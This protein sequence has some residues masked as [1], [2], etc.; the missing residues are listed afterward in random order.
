MHRQGPLPQLVEGHFRFG[1]WVGLV[2]RV[3][4]CLG[5]G[6]CVFC[7]VSPGVLFWALVLGWFALGF[8]V[9]VLLFHAGLLLTTCGPRT[10]G[11]LKTS[12]AD[13]QV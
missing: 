11:L 12:V 13:V 5:P 1:L 10:A 4:F 6:V 8:C 9:G 2:S 7:V 3:A